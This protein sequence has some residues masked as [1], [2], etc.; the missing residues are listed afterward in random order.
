MTSD[1]VWDVVVQIR[2][3]KGLNLKKAIL[4]QNADLYPTLKLTYNPYI[5]FGLE[6]PTDVYGEGENNFDWA[7]VDLVTALADGKLPGRRGR[8]AVEAHILQLTHSSAELFKC[9]LNKSMNFGLGETSINQ[10]LPGCIEIHELQL[11][12]PYEE[13]KVKFP[14]IISPKLNGLRGVFKNGQ[15]YSRKGHK[16][17]GLTKLTEEV[18]SLFG[19]DTHLDGELMVAGE[20]FNE[21]SGQI[22]SFNETD[23]AV[24]WIFDA[25]F[26]NDLP[27]SRRY[28]YLAVH[29][30]V[31]QLPPHLKLVPHTTVVSQAE[32]EA[33]TAEFYDQG[34]EGAMLKNPDGLYTH[35]RSFDW[36]KIKAKE[37]LDLKVIDTFPGSGKYVGAVGGVIVDHKGVHV[38]VAGLTDLQRWSWSDDPDIILG[39]TVEV[40]FQEVTPAGSLRHPRLLRVRGDK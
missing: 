40:E 9:I 11:A 5:Q 35:G 18:I 38:R 29:C 22:R 1:E 16:L 21:I 13:R 2:R 4:A 15:F 3:A 30:C 20:H 17:V 10:V 6:A 24:Y 23:N 14:C 36:M 26:L 33:R 39:K 27:L 12:K 7:T 32:V 37:S 31:P 25:P 34:Y 19:S 8:A 28:S